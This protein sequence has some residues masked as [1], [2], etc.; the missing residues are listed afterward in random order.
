MSFQTQVNIAQAPAAEG[1]F[2][3]NNPRTSMIAGPGGLV[4]GDA[5]GVNVGRFA[6]A[7]AAGLVT[8]QTATPNA[9]DYGFIARR[10]QALIVTFLAESG[11]NVPVGM[12]ITLMTRGSYW[13]RFAA[14][15]TFMQKVYFSFADGSLSAAATGAAST[16]TMTAN[17]ATNTTLTVTALAGGNVI[18]LGQP[19]SG[20]GIPAGAYI[21]AFGTGTGGAGTYTL[22]A[23][24][25]AT[26]TGVTVTNTLNKETAFIVGQTVAAGEIAKF[27]S[28]AL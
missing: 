7:N 13:G 15:A 22:S 12:P 18:A 5:N 20:S 6:W 21:S 17:T 26:A 2:A 8:T 9:S 11:M 25:T 3:D 28:G 27:S 14:G 23:A 16:S 10:Q 4:V 1:D 24:T 19:V